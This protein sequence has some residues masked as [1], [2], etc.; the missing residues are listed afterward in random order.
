MRLR[1]APTPAGPIGSGARDRWVTIQARPEDAT[2]ASGFPVD[3]PWVTLATVAMAREDMNALEVER[4]AQ[5]I[6]TTTTRW[7]TAYRPDCDPDRLDIPKL[8][9]LTYRDR[10]YDILAASTIGRRQALVF[11][12]DAKSKVPTETAVA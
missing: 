9:R 1:Q 3:R 7:E 4:S 5:Q 10:V 8:R 11:V 2:S 12:T 6:A